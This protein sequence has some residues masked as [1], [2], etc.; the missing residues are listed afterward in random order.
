[1]R[2]LFSVAAVGVC[3]MAALASEASAQT[4]QFEE[5]A[6]GQIE[7]IH[8]GMDGDWAYASELWL[9]ELAAGAVT[10][11]PLQISG[12][13]EYAIV[14]V[15]DSDCSDLDLLVYDPNQEQAAADVEE[16]D[17]PMVVVIG[18]GEFEVAVEMVECETATCVF[19]IQVFVQ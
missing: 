11:F 19:A 7:A 13:D 1:M 15:C 4:S 18:E 17:Y 16:D 14:G 9:G 6:I 10:T 12:S 2:N 3:M 8:A 5:E